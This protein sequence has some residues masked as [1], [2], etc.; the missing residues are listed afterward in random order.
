MN[1]PDEDALWRSIVENYGERAM[2]DPR[3]ERE[4]PGEGMA[5]PAANETTDDTA[6]ELGSRRDNERIVEPVDPLTSGVGDRLDAWDDPED[7]FVPPEP[8]P[9]PRLAPPQL[10]AWTGVFGTP[11]LTVAMAVLHLSIPLWA[12]LLA[13]IWFVGGFSFLVATM[14]RDDDDDEWDDGAVL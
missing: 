5:D 4:R 14:R 12:S 1:Q 9:L 3:A 13:L 2:L 6:Q 10:L 11:A 7:H 8:P